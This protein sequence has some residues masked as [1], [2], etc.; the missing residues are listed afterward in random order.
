MKYAHI[1]DSKILGWYDSDIHSDVPTGSI[2]INDNEW[3][4]ALEIN[5][6][7]Y[8]NN[9]FIFKDLRTSEDIEL[10]RILDINRKAEELI[11]TRYPE[12]KQLNII[13]LG[14]MDLDTMG[15]YIDYIRDT[16]NNAI[17]LGYPLSSVSWEYPYDIL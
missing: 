9:K 4:L 1:V 5:A 6:N 8:E 17:E 11:L 10:Q 16:S 14:G 13:R 2:P 15:R 7:Y 3:Q 12:Y